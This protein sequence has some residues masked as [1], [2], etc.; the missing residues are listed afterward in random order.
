[1]KKV[2]LLGDSIRKIG[3]GEPVA[4]ALSDQFTV[5]QPEENCRFAQ[6][7][8]RGL[9]D[10]RNEIEGADVVHWNNGLWDICHLFGDGP[11]T[12]VD[13]YVEEI[14]RIATILKQ[15][16]KAVIF[17][18]STPVRNENPYNRNTDIAAYNE[19]VIPHLREMG[20]RINDLYT[21][22]SADIPRYIREDDMIHLTEDGIRLCAK[23]VEESIRSAAEQTEASATAAVSV[24]DGQGAPV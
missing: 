12:P 13:R 8:L 22:I 23:L 4:S 6:Y 18:T 15:R 7:T 21:P 9:F 20:I 3:Y 17:A 10:W 14:L 1:M 5:W 2:I 11:F 16:A 24:H 19:A